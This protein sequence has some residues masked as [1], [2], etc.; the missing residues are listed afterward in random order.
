MHIKYPGTSLSFFVHSRDATVPK[1]CH[2]AGNVSHA[3]YPVEEEA[4]AHKSYCPCSVCTLHSS[5]FQAGKQG[6]TM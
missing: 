5:A 2:L 3:L 6:P 1:A 4:E